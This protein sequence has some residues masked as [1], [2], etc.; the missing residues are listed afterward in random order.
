MRR[1]SFAALF[2][3]LLT[4]AFLREASSQ[5]NLTQQL[6]PGVFYRVAERDK[7]IIANTGWVVFRDYVLV[8]DANYPWG[9]RPILDDIR[10]TTTKP[11]RYV[12]DTHYHGDHAWGNSVFVDAGATALCSEECVAES[13][14]KN[15]PSWAKNTETGEFSL[16]NYRL[17]HPQIGFRDKLVF[18]DGEHRVELLR[19]GPGHTRGD[20]I[21]YLP[22]E[23]ILF[24]GDLCVN[25][26]GNNVADVDADPDNWLR[27]LDAMG[28]F[29]VG[30]L[31][32]GHG[33]PGTIETIRGQ[34][35]YLADMI[36]GVRAAMEKGTSAE[37]LSKEMDLAKHKPWG[38]DQARNVTSIRA[39]YA[40]LSSKR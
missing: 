4:V 10:K 33:G 28:H 15:T 2:G 32:P 24:T 38:Q 13:K 25:F 3:L 1:A 35:A 30:R 27:A 34:R 21:A 11:I 16:K 26:A 40:K 9:A 37:Q 17:E 31:I 23:K 19:M 36:N 8:I 39:I 14:A 12:F 7:R 29:D 18:D 5:S 22:K 6:A 20:A